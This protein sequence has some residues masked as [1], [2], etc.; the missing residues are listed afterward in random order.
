MSIQL[1]VAIPT[2]NGS[3]T[4][5]TAIMPVISQIIGQSLNAHVL[6]SDNAS[7]DSTEVLCRDIESEYGAIFSY[8]R[9]CNNLEYDMNVNL[10]VEKAESEY[11]WLLSDNEVVS[12]SMALSKIIAY[13]NRHHVAFLYLDHEN[14]ICLKRDNDYFTDVEEFFRKIRFKSGLITNCVVARDCWMSLNMIRFDQCKWIHV[15]Y[16]IE[17]LSPLR[18]NNS[19]GIIYD[20][21]YQAQDETKRWGQNGSFVFTGLKLVEVFSHMKELGYSPQ[22]KKTADFVIKGGYPRNIIIA[23][24]Q[25]LC[26]S[27]DLFLRMKKLYG[28]YLSFWLVD[29]IALFFPK[30]ILQFFYKGYEWFSGLVRCNG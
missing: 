27:R 10:C 1:T 15:A 7:T 24:L 2:Y 16:Q 30:C 19:A 6:V 9:N 21:L 28:M 23:R 18:S 26:V 22:I 12:D 5:K 29:V 8:Y 3:N 20:Y 17:A 11:V 14:E 13:L 4:L 25:G